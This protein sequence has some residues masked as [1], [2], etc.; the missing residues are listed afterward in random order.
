MKQFSSCVDLRPHAAARV[1]AV[2]LGE[3]LE[4]RPHHPLRFRRVELSGAREPACIAARLRS[5][6]TGAGRSAPGVEDEAV[7]RQPELAAQP[8]EMSTVGATWR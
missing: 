1:K 8:A 2:I 4:P 7:G 3:L 5:L 6:G